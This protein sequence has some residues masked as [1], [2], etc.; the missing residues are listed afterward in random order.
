MEQST[1]TININERPK[2]KKGRPKGTALYAQEE[3]K[4]RAR[5]RARLNYSLNFE[6]ERERNILEYH[7]KRNIVQNSICFNFS[8]VNFHLNNWQTIY[9]RRLTNYTHS[10]SSK[11]MEYKLQI[12]YFITSSQTG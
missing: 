8:F 7:T 1:Q 3:A 11:V 6:K 12:I 5:Q 4:E 9:I 2:K 10:T